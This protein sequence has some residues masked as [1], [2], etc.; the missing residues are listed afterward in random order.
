MSPDAP[1]PTQDPST[2][3]E[4]ILF[5]K[6]KRASPKPKVDPEVI[7]SYA[8]RIRVA[9]RERSSY[10]LMEF[11]ERPT[12]DAKEVAQD[13]FEGDLP[14]VAQALHSLWVINR[15]SGFSHE[16]EEG[17][18]LTQC[19]QTA[20]AD[21]QAAE[22]FGEGP[23]DDLKYFR[24]LLGE[25]FEDNQPPAGW[26]LIPG[27]VHW[28]PGTHPSQ[29]YTLLFPKK[30]RAKKQADEGEAALKAPKPKKAPKEK[31]PQDLRSVFQERLKT[32]TPDKLS[33]PWMA[34]KALR[35]VTDPEDLRAW[36]EKT[37]ADTSRHRAC[38]TGEVMPV[39]GVDTE[40]AADNGG[41]SGLDTRMVCGLPQLDNAG[42]CLSSDGVEGLYVPLTHEDGHNCPREAVREILQPLFDKSLL[43]FFNSKYDREVLTMTIG[44]KLRPYP[45]FEDVQIL[46]FLLDPKSPEEEEV[47]SFESA[48]LK[49]LA[50]RYTGCEMLELG[51]LAK[52]KAR[53]VNPTTGKASYRQIL[54][55]FN[56]IP[57]HL[58]LPYAAGDGIFTWLLWEMLHEEARKMKFV[59]RVDHRLADALA[60]I[61][62]Q[63]PLI[64]TNKHAVICRWHAEKLAVL[65]EE[66]VELS[67]IEDFNP[68]STPQL[69][70]VLFETY[71]FP[72]I[73]RSAKTGEP[74]TDAD[75]IEELMK[76]RPG[77]PFLKALVKYRE[78]AALHPAHLS[79]DPRDHTARLYF[80]QCT[81]AGGRLAA[82]GGKFEVDG[83]FGLNPQAIVA[84]GGSNMVTLRRLR[85]EDTEDLGDGFDPTLVPELTIDEV[86]PSCTHTGKEKVKV[87]NP[88][89]VQPPPLPAPVGGDMD[90]WG[91]AERAER[92]AERLR[93]IEAHQAGI[94]AMENI[95]EFLEVEQPVHKVVIPRVV[96]NHV[97]RYCG[98]WWSLAGN[99][100]TLILSSG[101]EIPLD[102]PKGVDANEV[103]NIRSL[104][105]AP[106]GYS[107]FVVDYSNIEMRV[108][109]NVSLEPKFIEE[110][111]HGSGD[112]HTLTAK[113]VFP[114]FRQLQVRVKELQAQ[115]PRGLDPE[116]Q[117]EITKAKAKMKK[118][119]SMA[120]IINFALLYGG[121]DYAIFEGMKAEDPTITRE[122][123]ADMVATYW[124]SV[125]Y[126]KEWAQT[127]MARARETFTCKTASGRR[128]DF[129][130]AMRAQKITEPLPEHWTNYRA[131][132]DL[133][134]R[135]EQA[136][137]AGN[138]ELAAE[139]EARAQEMRRDKATGVANLGDYKKFVSKIQRVATNAPLQGLAGDFMRAALGYIHQWA[140]S[141]GLGDI[142]LLHATV[143]D[144]IDFS[145]KNEYVPY[146]IPRIIRLMKL[147]TMHAAMKWPV[148][149]EC[150]CEYGPSW[151]VKEHLTGDDTHNPAGYTK[152]PGLADYIPAMFDPETVEALRVALVAPDAEVRKEVYSYLASVTHPR[153]HGNIPKLE[154]L[155][156]QKAQAA[157]TAILQLHE[158]WLIDQASE[159]GD[160]ET[161]EEYQIRM[162]LVP[163]E[164]IARP[165]L[166]PP[167]VEAVTPDVVPS[168]SPTAPQPIEE[169]A[170]V[171]V[172]HP[173]VVDVPT[174]PAPTGA[175]RPRMVEGFPVLKDLSDEAAAALR[176]AM[177]VGRKVARVRTPDGQLLLIKQ[178]S[179]EEIPSEF[180][181][182]EPVD[183]CDEG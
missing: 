118:L 103:V 37:L 160:D 119:R 109:A 96:N 126:F 137:K 176:S 30:T 135:A 17:E 59:H 128:I 58:A 94:M 116:I 174:A 88:A 93:Q 115:D 60:W 183:A 61:E 180:L 159:E 23:A 43:V 66:L 73:K 142:L 164:I 168:A 69:A 148:P 181:V 74:S 75:V 114:E 173:E 52:V 78:Y 99:E 104:F 101:L 85:L 141:A 97:A 80:K 48:G 21:P 39:I 68:G 6:K 121:T 15:D 89:Y 38:I 155:P 170:Q 36:A 134:R 84:V 65:K 81:V 144:E 87:P 5:A 177:G 145:V 157:L 49:A 40:N 71:G 162:G 4:P 34:T 166:P 117:G 79:Y 11:L 152:I 153:C 146:V 150:D 72:V 19:W 130:S 2:Q 16:F 76:A 3:E 102:P 98:E 28:V 70:R 44:L 29:A 167:P 62:R 149:I 47:S 124:D 92:E 163:G 108:A 51:T 90:D 91:D 26:P 120:K 127:Q 77:H 179:S 24:W 67:G 111:I 143:H 57:T 54:A 178:T 33:K 50:L 112:F 172:Q 63:R 136:G 56:W 147:R 175:L 12:F 171:E 14:A 95:P 182:M 13:L 86:H 105:V 133:R 46:Q 53:Y 9:E 42:I 18:V 25:D 41:A 138:K 1:M 132:W 83:G 158:Y 165:T 123:A 122:R 129:K 22:I 10:Y 106:E 169:E 139:L 35:L 110:F 113:N 100:D 131:F 125:P 31:P 20:L 140:I 7:Q 107:F 154:G 156:P 8:E 27:E 151:D 45:Y 55:P 32:L 64:D 161:V 82:M